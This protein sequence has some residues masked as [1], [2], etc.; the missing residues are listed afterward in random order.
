MYQTAIFSLLLFVIIIDL[1]IYIKKWAHG[2]LSALADR[3]KIARNGKGDG[4]TCSTLSH[5]LLFISLGYCNI[6]INLSIQY[7]LNCGKHKAGS[8]HGGSH[9]GAYEFIKES[10]FVPYDTCMPY[11]ACSEESKEGICTHVDTTCSAMNICKTCDTFAG[12]GG[13]CVSIDTFPNATGTPW[14]LI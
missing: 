9:S 10:G 8:C 6:D 14:T 7:I 3:I 11:L 12:M 4:T 1:I 2:A 13:N 5:F